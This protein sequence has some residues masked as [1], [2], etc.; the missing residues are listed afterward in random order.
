MN[1][2][3]KIRIFLSVSVTILLLS[4]SGLVYYTFFRRDYG[5]HEDFGLD[6]NYRGST[7]IVDQNGTGDYFEID[8][9]LKAA[10]DG[11]TIRVYSGLYPGYYFLDKRVMMIGNGST[12]ILSSLYSS[13]VLKVK[14]GVNEV[15]I[16]SLTFITPEG[17]PCDVGI[18]ISSDRNIIQGC[19]FRGDFG[20]EVLLTDSGDCIVRSN[21]FEDPE[22]NTSDVD[23]WL[24]SGV[25]LDHCR[26]VLVKG[27]SF[28]DMDGSA[29]EFEWT[30]RCAFVEN[31]LINCSRG[32]H[33][34]YGRY[35]VV[36]DN[37]Y[38]NVHSSDIWD[39]SF[40]TRIEE[41]EDVEVLVGYH[42]TPWANI[43]LWGSAIF[44]VI[45]LI[46]AL[47]L[48]LVGKWVVG[49]IRA[50]GKAE[51]RTQDGGENRGR[52][53]ISGSIDIEKTQ[54]DGVD[55]NGE[56]DEKVMEGPPQTTVAR[57]KKKIRWGTLPVIVFNSIMFFIS[58]IVSVALLL[59]F[60]F[61]NFEI[62]FLCFFPLLP[63]SLLGIFFFGVL[64]F[65]SL[66]SMVRRKKE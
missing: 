60:M 64:L 35:D 33:L 63:L 20:N 65:G 53:M 2:G 26:S 27:N 7:I 66:Y 18:S 25:R 23:H 36:K 54:K 44:M 12:T 61:A 6:L 58:L 8:D 10:S 22:D 19:F 28:V 42:A 4:A 9:A 51:R 62:E 31:H 38:Q 30:S 48:I 14:D 15:T 11:D 57:K 45:F 24:E 55:Q 46:L 41:D 56:N 5:W 43:C 50:T 3:M 52:E 17:L 1:R 29:A 47:D 59:I 32:L 34:E 16:E 49:K 39:E 37:Q 40:K 13:H 21:F